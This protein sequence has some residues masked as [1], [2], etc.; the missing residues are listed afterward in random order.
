MENCYIPKKRSTN[1]EILRIILMLLIIGHHYV[2]NSGL[3]QLIEEN[4]FSANSIFLVVISS[5][6]KISIN[7]FVLIT[8]YFMCQSK[9]TFKKYFRLFFEVLFYNLIFFIVFSIF[10]SSNFSLKNLLFT[11]FPFYNIDHLFISCFLVFYL[12][13]PFINLLIK[14]MNQKSHFLLIIVLLLFF[15]LCASVPKFTININ[16]VFWC[17]V[18]Y[19]I[20]AYLRL[21]PNK[22]ICNKIFV[23]L[24]SLIS[25]VVCVLGTIGL[26]YVKAKF[27]GLDYLDMYFIVADSNKILAVITSVF[28]FIFFINLRV[29]NIKI[30]NL[31]S[32]TTFGVLCIHANSDAMRK[33]LWCDFLKNVEYY[34]HN[35]YLHCIISIFLVF[36]VCAFLD[37]LRKYL[38]EKYFFRFIDKYINKLDVFFEK[39]LLFVEEKNEK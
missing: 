1:L 5:F 32:S 17:F 24:G 13:I 21:Y 7:C 11:I 16:Y 25:L 34:N 38:I 36:A 28:I 3:L 23:N 30:I 14:S 26:C 27:S 37:F 19:I 4:P 6:G 20:G 18:M 22:L 10:D 33:W 2:M 9:F 31:I 29:P 15:S 35:I 8:G 12:F 39:S